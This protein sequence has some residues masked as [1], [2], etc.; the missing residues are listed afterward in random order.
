MLLE[1]IIISTGC[2]AHVLAALRASMVSTPYIMT[3]IRSR[4]VTVKLDYA[5][6]ILL[7]LSLTETVYPHTIGLYSKKKSNIGS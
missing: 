4:I 5:C 3:V 6:C 7:F 2:F 1:I